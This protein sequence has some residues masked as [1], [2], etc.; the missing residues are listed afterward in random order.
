MGALGFCERSGRLMRVLVRVL[1][2][3]SSEGSGFLLLLLWWWWWWRWFVVLLLLVEVVVVVL[4]L[5]CCCCCFVDGGGGVLLLKSLR[6]I[7]FERF[8]FRC[9]R[10]VLSLLCFLPSKWGLIWSSAYLSA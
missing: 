2:E 6:Q 10:G 9:E 3:G 4:V 1:G 5:F 7:L 8:L